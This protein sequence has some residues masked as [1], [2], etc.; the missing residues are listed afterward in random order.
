MAKILRA[1]TQAAHPNDEVLD[2]KRL[3]E[4]PPEKTIGE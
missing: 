1:E 2:N 3:Y 4:K